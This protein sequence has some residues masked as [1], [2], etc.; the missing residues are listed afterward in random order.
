MIYTSTSS[1]IATVDYFPYQFNLCLCT[2]HY[3][4]C[5]FSLRSL[6]SMQTEYSFPYCAKIKNSWSY[7]STPQIRLH[8]V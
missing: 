7:T 4:C 5:W 3:F 8:G 6:L 1:N 2:V